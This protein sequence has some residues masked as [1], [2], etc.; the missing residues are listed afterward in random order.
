[1]LKSYS[2]QNNAAPTPTQHFLVLIKLQRKISF[3][4]SFTISTWLKSTIIFIILCIW[5]WWIQKV[6]TKTNKYLKNVETII[7]GVQQLGSNLLGLPQKVWFDKSSNLV[8]MCYIF[9]VL[10][11]YCTTYMYSRRK[12]YCFHQNAK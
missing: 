7:R 9:M 5:E 6:W 8:K 1:M 4:T 11:M 2:K 3:V 10:A 12:Y